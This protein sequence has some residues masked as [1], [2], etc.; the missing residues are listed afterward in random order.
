M[1]A[2]KAKL[3]YPYLRIENANVL[4]RSLRTIKQ[5]CEIEAMREAEK[6]TRDG[7]V[8]MMKASRPGMY[9]YQYKSGI[10]L[11]WDSTGRRG[12]PS[13]PLFL[14]GKIISVSIII[15]IKDRPGTE[16]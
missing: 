10:R 11:R 3:E 8:A 5:A 7:I 15:N 4:I 12:R 16:I 13:L 9:E 6:I 2:K 1:L 14:P